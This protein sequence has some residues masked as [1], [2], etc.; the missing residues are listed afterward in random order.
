MHRKGSTSQTRRRHHL[1]AAAVLAAVTLVGCADDDAGTAGTSYVAGD[2]ASIV[3]PAAER[4]E[5]VRVTGTTL[6]GDRLDTVTLR[7]KPVVLNVWGSWCAP[8]RKEAADLQAASQ[9]L[10]A[11]GVAFIGINTRD[12][13]AQARAFERTYKITYPSLDDPG[14]LLLS[15]RGA[16]PPNAIPTTLVLDDQG[17]IAARFSGPVTRTTLI[18][19]VEDA[20]SP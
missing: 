16:V 18:G 14:D 13:P 5:P 3:L 4:Q 2:G 6:D 20:T 1:P 19:L 8:C 17:R 10:A 11:R 12:Q 9:E 15:L 7:G